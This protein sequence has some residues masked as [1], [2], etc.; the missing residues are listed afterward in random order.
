MGRK[1][2]QYASSET[3]SAAQPPI[4]NRIIHERTN[5]QK[6]VAF[7][8]RFPVAG[9]PNRTSS[10][11]SQ[12]SGSDI[13][14]PWISFSLVSDTRKGRERLSLCLFPRTFCFEIYTSLSRGWKGSSRD[15]P[16]KTGKFCSSKELFS[17]FPSGAFIAFVLR[18]NAPPLIRTGGIISFL[19]GAME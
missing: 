3:S 18:L 10:F 12:I 11:Q 19:R 4:L 7:R 5:H 9:A 17:Q 13:I 8:S 1:K 6:N 14:C 16:K 15:E 2:K